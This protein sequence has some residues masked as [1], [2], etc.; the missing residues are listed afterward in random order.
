MNDNDFRRRGMDNDAE[1]CGVAVRCSLGSFT[2]FNRWID[3][4]LAQLE[5]R[6]AHVAA[7]AQ[8]DREARI[9]GARP[10]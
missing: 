2:R 8:R 10:R 7:P 5:R 1:T 3:G 6:W 4:Q 9:R